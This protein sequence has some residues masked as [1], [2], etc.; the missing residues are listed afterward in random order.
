MK[1]LLLA[2]PVFAVFAV[3]A[4]HA[5]AQAYQ[6]PFNLTPVEDPLGACTSD[7]TADECMALGI[8][9]PKCSDM[10]VTGYVSCV[11]KCTCQYNENVK[12]CDGQI[13]RDTQKA[14][15]DACQYQCQIDWV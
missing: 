9:K 7:M 3:W 1:K 15:Y 2:I 14:D 5:H 8:K 4:P 11:A 13:C 6:A 10:K 12:K